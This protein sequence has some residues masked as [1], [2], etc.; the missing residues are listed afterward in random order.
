GPVAVNLRVNAPLQRDQS[1][2]ML[3]D[4]AVDVVD[5][6]VLRP[7]L[8][9]VEAPGLMKHLSVPGTR[10]DTWPNIP[11]VPWK[12]SIR[13]NVAAFSRRLASSLMLEVR[14]LFEWDD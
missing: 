2:W 9:S 3:D 14:L 7:H 13:V 10:T 6:H 8:L 4:G 11:I 5:E 1:A 12:L